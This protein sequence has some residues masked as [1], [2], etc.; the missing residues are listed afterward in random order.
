MGARIFLYPRL[1]SVRIGNRY[2]FG[3]G[4]GNC[5]F[6]WARAVVASDHY[7][8]P[9]L[10]P[11][12][13]RFTSGAGFRT[14]LKGIFG[15]KLS[16]RTYRGLFSEP[17]F[18]PNQVGQIWKIQ[19]SP[20]R[21]ESLL[22]DL[23]RMGVKHD[24]VVVFHG[25]R[26]KF[27][28]LLEHQQLVTKA[29]CKM[30]RPEILDGAGDR[31]LIRFACHVRLGDFNPAGV[32]RATTLDNARLPMEWYIA[33]IRQISER[34]PGSTIDLFS[35]GTAGELA[36]FLQLSNVRRLTFGNPLADLLAMSR[37]SLLV[38]N[39]STFSAWAAY[40][41]NMPTIWFPTK[42]MCPLHPGIPDYEIESTLDE[43]LSPSFCQNV[44]SPLP[45]M[46]Y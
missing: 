3:A 21:D 15:P 6:P 1:G 25:S 17:P 31:P 28:S 11:V 13:T 32:E 41:G 10:P 8:L 40:L 46:I 7:G 2:L 44:E 33:K 34:W 27:T 14:A 29:F 36:P 24:T 19:S 37:S 5:L 12:W 26:G 45:N 23:V 16:S 35:D 30:I 22:S 4:L 43:P 18:F 38:C 9:L 42:L 20:K 39:G